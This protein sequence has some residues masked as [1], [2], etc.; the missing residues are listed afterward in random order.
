MSGDN[1]YIVRD[2]I[3]V[4]QKEVVIEHQNFWP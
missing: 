2:G 4:S 3:F 1:L